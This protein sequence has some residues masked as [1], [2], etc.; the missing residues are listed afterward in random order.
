MS[1]SRPFAYNPIPPNSF[2]S[3]TDQVGDIAIGVDPTLG[4]TSNVGGVQWWM[5]PDEELG[6]VIAQ[7]VPSLDQPNPLDIPAGIG[8]YRSEFLTE[9]S[10]IS[11][12]NNI[13]GQSFISG[14][15]A[16]TYLTSN[17]YWSSWV[18]TPVTPTQTPTNTKTP[19][20]TITS[21]VTPTNTQTPTKT[22]TQTPTITPTNTQTPTK[23]QTQTPTKTITPTNTQTPTNTS[24]RTTPTS[25]Q[26]PTA[27]PPGPNNYILSA[28]S[29]T[30]SGVYKDGSLI[31]T[32]WSNVEQ[33][34]G[35]YSKPVWDGND[36]D[37]N[38]VALPATITVQA[39]QMDYTWSAGIGNTSTETEGP[40]K[41]RALRQIWGSVISGN[42]LYCVT[43]F[44]EGDSPIFKVDKTGNINYRLQVLPTTQNDVVFNTQYIARDSSRIYFAGFDSYGDYAV[45]AIDS[46]VYAI[47]VSDDSKYTFPSGT[48]VSPALSYE[49]FSCIA[50]QYN[51]PTA[52]ITGLDVVQ[53]SNW[54]YVTRR[55]QSKVEVYNKVTGSGSTVV[56]SEPMGDISIDGTTLWGIIGT[57][58]V[59]YSINTGT[60]ALTSAGVTISMTNPVKVHAS[61]GNVYV[62]DASTM[63]V[64]M[65]NSS[66][67]SQW[68]FGQFSGYTNSPYAA[69][70]KFHFIDSVDLIR[71]GVIITDSSNG[72]IWIGD[73][74]NNRMMRYNS[75]RTF[76]ENFSYLPMFYN[77]GVNI[78][79]GER[80]FALF[81]EFNS[82]TEEFVANWEANLWLISP[83]SDYIQ[84][85]RRDI[86]RNMWTI[87]G[88]TFATI[89][90]YSA[91]PGI[92][93]PEV[94]ELTSTGIRITGIQWDYYSSDII[95]NNGDIISFPY[96]EGTSGTQ[97]LTRQVYT[98]LNGSNNPQWNSPITISSIPLAASSPTF[99]NLSRPSPKGK[100]FSPGWQNGGRHYGRYA[101][102]KWLWKVAPS[103]SESYSGPWLTDGTFDCGNGIPAFGGY[104]GWDTY[105][106]D[107]MNV[108]NYIGEGWKNS[109]VNKWT[110]YHDRGLLLKQIG[111]T[112]P[113]AE[114]DSGT[115][116]APAQAAGN[117]IAGGFVKI[118]TKYYI[119]HCDE[120]VHGA[121]HRFEIDGYSTIQTFDFIEV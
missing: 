17:G 30:S 106:V 120:S 69:N 112:T 60:G 34:A 94:V 85:D 99:A 9:P 86:F 79:D 48:T 80:V 11:L 119:F 64:N 21:T 12:S 72:D 32:L 91:G 58:V 96:N 29:T 61:G 46:C 31:R 22:Q 57:N 7:S 108:W 116:Q 93:F 1:V 8:F 107:D 101:S 65:Y 56:L 95:T 66:G 35:T 78:N 25:T 33:N 97:N 111:K 54:L 45:D 51:D 73:T 88:H 26:T 47:N 19:T 104:A 36:D 37:G 63:Q 20:N 16:S 68:T 6:Y 44:V 59:K 102:G 89:T 13:T 28:N 52:Q 14:D 4:Y 82:I 3:G 84:Y 77:C 42:Y 10:F 70:D 74:G 39:N 55:A 18:P 15:A 43:G 83:S 62:I 27:T 118:G 117:A 114:A 105:E 75:S 115:N 87:D 41:L 49:T 110:I 24:T 76:L 121:I 71:R 23:T 67:T 50:L 2:I 103:T 109:Q 92:R 113:E 40:H 98:G 81:Q 100:V 90:N 53:S 5:G 38:P